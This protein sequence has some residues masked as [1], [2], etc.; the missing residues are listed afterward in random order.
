MSTT[1][2]TLAGLQKEILADS[3]A[4]F[5]TM[6]DLVKAVFTQS[7]GDANTVNFKS[8]AVPGVVSAHTENAAITAGAVSVG[9]VPAALEEY[10]ALAKISGLAKVSDGTLDVVSTDIAGQLAKTADV[11]IGA[12]YAGFTEVVGDVATDLVI[13]DFFT[14]STLLDK[15][16]FVGQK[17]CALDPVTWNKFGAGLIALSSP[18]SK[19]DEYMGRGYV[20]NVGGVEIYVNS[21]IEGDTGNGM[22]FKEAL[23]FGYREPLIEISLDVNLGTNSIDVLGASYFKAIEITDGAGVTLIDKTPA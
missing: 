13:A 18:G 1:K 6:S 16:G 14:A 17:V 10:V 5:R 4:K 11:L 12:L 8:R 2:A 3:M 22:Y 15:T 21:W 7:A 23:G 19:A 9:Q 20:A